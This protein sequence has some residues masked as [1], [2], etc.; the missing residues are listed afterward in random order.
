MLPEI[1]FQNGAIWCVLVDI[2]IRFRLKI[3]RKIIIFCIENNYSS[4]THLLWGI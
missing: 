3:E 2:L 4:Y 1:F